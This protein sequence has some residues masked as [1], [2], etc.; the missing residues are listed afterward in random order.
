MTSSRSAEPG[1]LH[2]L[3][4]TGVPNTVWD[5][6]VPLTEAERERARLSPYLTER[7]LRRPTALAE[8]GAIASIVFERM[9]GSGYP[10]GSRGAAIPLLARYLAAADVYHGMREERPHRPALTAAEAAAH[11][12][13]EIRA[14]RLDAA[15][16]EAVLDVAGHRAR[17]RTAAPGGLT[18]REV[19]VLVLVARGATTRQV[20]R[21][22]GITTKTAGNHVERAYAKCGVSSRSAATLYAMQHG[23]LHTLE[24]LTP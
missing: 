10:H 18:P 12:R 1:L 13:A 9:D 21:K 17:G 14:G 7:M 11:V 16:G 15:A 5:K 20:G 24:P 23:L 8:L 2:D 19:E 6:A 22:L 4:R 3:G